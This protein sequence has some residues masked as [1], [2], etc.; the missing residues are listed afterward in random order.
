MAERVS[1]LA[2]R[3]RLSPCSIRRYIRHG[4][5]PAQRDRRNWWLVQPI[6]ADR[7]LMAREGPIPES[8]A[9]QAARMVW[10]SPGGVR[11][12]LRRN[13]VEPANAAHFAA[14]YLSPRRRNGDRFPELSGSNS[15]E[16]GH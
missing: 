3:A 9:R 8:L 14:W 1:E 15:A 12:H 6:D 10:L 2:R 7:F 16:T 11:Y 4:I 13:Q 5:I